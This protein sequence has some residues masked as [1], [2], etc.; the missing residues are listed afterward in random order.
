MHNSCSRAIHLALKPFFFS[1]SNSQWTPPGGILAFLAAG[2]F[3]ESLWLVESGV[4]FTW[5]NQLS[6]RRGRGLFVN[7]CFANQ[8][9]FWGLDLRSSSYASYLARFYCSTVNK[10]PWL[11][12]AVYSST[13][14]QQTYLMLI[15]RMV[16]QAI[17]GF[18][19]LI[20][21]APTR[22]GDIYQALESVKSV[23][24]SPFLWQL[25]LLKCEDGGGAAILW[26]KVSKTSC[27]KRCSKL[28]RSC[29]NLILLYFMNL[30]A[31]DCHASSALICITLLCFGCYTMLCYYLLSCTILFFATLRYLLCH[32]FFPIIRS[33]VLYVGLLGYAILCLCGWGA[34][35]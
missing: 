34:D 31:L 7:W 32:V 1:V 17:R 25:I 23:E 15:D 10:H 14:Q 19:Y 24:T 21:G 27:A 5:E 8:H 4:L 26:R 9:R 35:Y 22:G 28:P 33:S 13:V 11:K 3:V 18:L 20:I 12:S 2:S 6:G 29:I 16:Y 30:G